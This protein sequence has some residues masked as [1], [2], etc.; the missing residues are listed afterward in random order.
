MVFHRKVVMVGDKYMN[1][2]KKEH[3]EKLKMLNI[4]DHVQQEWG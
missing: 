3:R 1:V 2:Y 4:M